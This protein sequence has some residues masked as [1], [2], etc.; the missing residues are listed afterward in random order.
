VGERPSVRNDHF[1]TG[2]NL[3]LIIKGT[4]DD[5]RQQRGN[6]RVRA[7]AAERLLTDRRERQ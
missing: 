7:D 1:R 2:G 4:R 6:W 5:L 3:P